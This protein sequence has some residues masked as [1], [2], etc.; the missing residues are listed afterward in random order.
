MFT[1]AKDE[2][3][4]KEY[5]CEEVTRLFT[6]SYKTKVA[7]TTKRIIRTTT[8]KKWGRQIAS[9]QDVDIDSIS[10]FS[11]SHQSYNK[12][13]LGL[14]FGFGWACLIVGI[15]FLGI[16]IS[17]SVNQ[18]RASLFAV[19]TTLIPLGASIMLKGTAPS[20]T[21][22]GSGPL[23]TLTFMTGILL[24]FTGSFFLISALGIPVASLI[25][26]MYEFVLAMTLPPI[27]LTF[28]SIASRIKPNMRFEIH[29]KYTD[30]T[31]GV[32]RRNT[33]IESLRF[34][35]PAS[36]QHM[37][38]ELPAIVRDIKDYGTKVVSMWTTEETSQ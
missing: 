9:T 31:F 38:E 19:A 5:S 30:V 18:E 14:L 25:F 22:T 33:I 1:L 4:I 28:I 29:I 3:I 36:M 20:S 27:G 35:L 34:N 12:T 24:L 32:L 17:N 2:K 13:I 26:R 10:G 6:M 15:V 7:I 37:F 8:G 16:F 11:S 23:R 21:S